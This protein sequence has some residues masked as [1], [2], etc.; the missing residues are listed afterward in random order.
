LVPTE[1]IEI[2]CE[3]T[4]PRVARRF[5]VG[6]LGDD[7]RRDDAALLTSELVTNAVQH[8]CTPVGVAVSLT[9]DRLRVEV[10]D[11]STAVAALR[12][13]DVNGGRGL[14]LVESISSRWGVVP[15]GGGKVVWFEL[16]DRG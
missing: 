4:S 1:R 2:P 3:P 5:V 10:T 6:R 13:P 14:R 16:D 7:E 9:R 11:R 15:H 12:E 8:A